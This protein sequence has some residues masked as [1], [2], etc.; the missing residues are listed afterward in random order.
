MPSLFALCAL[1]ARAQ[2]PPPTSLPETVVTAPRFAESASA[3]PFGVSVLTADEIQASGVSTVNEAVMKL[4]GVVGRQ[5]F[6][7]GGDFSLD[8]RGF[9]STADS[10]Q[11][12]VVDGIRLSEADQGGTRL[13]GIPIDSVERIEVLRGS[14]AVLYGEGATGGVIVITT[15]AGTGAARRNTASLSYGAGS[16]G[17]RDARVNA[18]LASGGLSMD[19]SGT[20]RN[21]DNH[22]DNFRS[23]T[24]AGS[25]AV[26]WSN[27]RVRLGA[28]YAR[29]ELET[30]LPGALSADQF[31]TNPKQTNNPD[32]H[33]SI[34]NTRTSVFGELFL[35]GW[36]LGADAGWRDKAVDSQLSGF[37]FAF[38][39]D[40][41]N[42]SLR[43]RHEAQW[44]GYKNILVAG[45]DYGRWEREVLGSFGSTARQTSRGWYLKDDVTLPGVATRISAGVRTEKLNKTSTNAPTGLAD[46][47]TAWELG[48]SQPV[49]AGFTLYGRLGRSF[50]LANVDEFSFTS[51]GVDLLAQRSHDLELGSRLA[52]AGG[53]VELRL[54][55]SNLRNEIGFDPSAAGPFG[56]GAN[57]NFD[58]TRRQGLEL[59]TSHRLARAVTLR[60]NAAWRESTFRS[61]AYAGHDVPLAPT[62]SVA[63]RAD[64]QPLAQHRVTGGVNWVSSQHPDFDNR[65]RMPSYATADLRY[66][67][68]WQQ[69]E[70]SLG[71]SNL[72]DRNFYTQAFTCVSGVTNGIFPEAGRAF[73]ATARVRF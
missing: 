31:A 36:Q 72:F 62:Q 37:P 7:G 38:N 27:D 21:A 20:Q 55:R 50:R 18:T 6:F 1:P 29:D 42:Y 60:V 53:K 14:G 61:G 28:R 44:G 70:L 12:V 26:Q 45:T 71:V 15:K 17:L 43:A 69:V 5:D 30:R 52:Y 39:I 9:G 2:V 65:C 40:A 57:V 22:R 66:A 24:D 58:P 41:N 8:L 23:E 10:N 49:G 63:V 68:H 56:P 19:F 4:L 73:T 46:R 25:L 11:I 32:D 16:Y 64:W 54:Y 51:P 47:Q 33:A 59:D 34:N 35:G 13:A 48:T 3:L 67:Y